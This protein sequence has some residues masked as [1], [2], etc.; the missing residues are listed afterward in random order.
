MHSV[1]DVDGGVDMILQSGGH[2][3]SQT[4]REGESGAD[5]TEVS[6]S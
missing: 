5:W 4:G 2:T 3:L 1:G 6:R